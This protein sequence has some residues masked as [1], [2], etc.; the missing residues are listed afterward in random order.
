MIIA[1]DSNF[2]SDTTNCKWTLHL[3]Y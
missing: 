3:F 1:L 2:P